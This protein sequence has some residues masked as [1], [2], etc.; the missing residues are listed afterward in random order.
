MAQCDGNMIPW[1]PPEF[2]NFPALRPL[3][4]TLVGQEVAEYTEQ[5]YGERTDRYWGELHRILRETTTS[6]AGSRTQEWFPRLNLPCRLEADVKR[7][8]SDDDP[9]PP[10][11]A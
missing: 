10:P 8:W 11:L 5:S 2:L 7:R 4:E 3:L 6:L 1:S 9:P